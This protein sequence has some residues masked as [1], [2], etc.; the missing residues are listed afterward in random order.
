MPATQSRRRA[1]FGSQV[2]LDLYDCETTHLDDLAWVKRTL[3]NAARAA[4][5]TI[6]ETVFHKFSPWGISGVVVI[7]ESHL[8]IHIWPEN[9]YAAVDVFTCGAKVR[10]DVASAFLAREFQSG[11]TLQRRF[12]RGDHISAN[13]RPS[14]DPD[15]RRVLRRAT[16]PSSPTATRRWAT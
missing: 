14:S 13:R 16:K 15:R 6:V 10:M 12:T 11:R 5:A 3:I 8:A 2:V 4:G 1:V 9:R 7:A